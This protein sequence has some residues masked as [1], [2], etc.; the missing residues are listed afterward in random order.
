MYR[1]NVRGAARVCR[2]R[3]LF[4]ILFFEK[5]G[6][7]LPQNRKV[8]P[9][10]ENGVALYSGIM[11]YKWRHSQGRHYQTL[12]PSR[13]PSQSPFPLP[14]QTHPSAPCVCPPVHFPREL[15]IRTAELLCR[16]IDSLSERC[17]VRYSTRYG[18]NFMP[19][20][21]VQKRGR[22]GVGE[23]ARR[24]RT[25]GERE[26]EYSRCSV[27]AVSSSIGNIF[28]RDR[29]YEPL[30]LVNRSKLRFPCLLPLCLLSFRDFA[31]LR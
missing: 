16:L 25:D 8:R 28:C 6:G 31:L 17:E 18:F 30:I 15:S 9:E 7:H 26:D 3:R 5:G 2:P 14:S 21:S 10:K 20:I 24:R 13:I 23:R 19:I 22:R 1:A 4:R 29:E 12:A 11:Y 27:A